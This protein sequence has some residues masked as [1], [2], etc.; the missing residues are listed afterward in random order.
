MVASPSLSGSYSSWYFLGFAR[1]EERQDLAQIPKTTCNQLFT[2][3]ARHLIY[4]VDQFLF[5]SDQMKKMLSESQMH[6]GVTQKT[7]RPNREKKKVM[8]IP[9]KT[10]SANKK[11]SKIQPENKRCQEI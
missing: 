2:I 11:M 8:G 10:K 9:K 7:M 6:G 5:H 3:Y 1:T 4:K